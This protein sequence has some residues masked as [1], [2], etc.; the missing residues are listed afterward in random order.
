MEVSL[1]LN[2][3]SDGLKFS[4]VGN[5][6]CEVSGIGKCKDKRVVIPAYS[7][8]LFSRLPVTGIGV[9]AFFMSKAEEV[10]IPFGVR[11]I[12]DDAFENCSSLFAVS[13]PDS[14]EEICGGAFF[15]CS[16]LR[17][18]NLPKNLK[19]IGR[20][21]FSLC[22]EL[23]RV[24]IP[25]SV[26]SIEES[27][28]SSCASLT[29]IEADPENKK[30]K[31]GV[32][33]LIDTEKKALVWGCAK[34]VIPADGSV[35]AI[36][37]RAFSG[38]ETIERVVIPAPVERIGSGAFCGCS[39]LSEAVL[40]DTVEVIENSAFSG[41]D[42]LSTVRLGAGVREIED[43]A[44][45]HSERIADVYYNGTK[46]DWDKIKVGEGNGSLAEARMHFLLSV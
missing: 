10:I 23:E 6:E 7:K 30:Y 8:K 15:C 41:C 18:I 27:A 33:C 44:F 42:I 19:S 22:G 17:E 40:A 45:G 1:N 21:A 3:E 12:G 26:T 13:L 16:S 43:H 31:S 39:E 20:L 35:T 24:E 36:A 37:P 38:C 32:S 5:G 28:F 34:T 46:E 14:L 11:V 2:I 25:A 9:R 4:P 29:E